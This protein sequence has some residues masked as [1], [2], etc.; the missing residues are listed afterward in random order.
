[1]PALDASLDAVAGGGAAFKAVRGEYGSGKTFLTRYVAE[2]A[3]GEGL[4][5]AEVQI[6]ETET[7]LH[8]LETVYRRIRE[9]LRTAAY[10]PSA[11]RPVLDSWLF[12]LESDAM[13]STRT[14][15]GADMR[16]STP[17]SSGCWRKGSP[18]SP[19]HTPAFRPG[20]ARLPCR[21]R[22]RGPAS[23]DALAILAWRAAACR[24]RR[25]PQRRNPRRTGSFRGDGIPAG[26][27]R[28]CS[29]T[30]AILGCCWCWTRSRPCS[31]SA[32]TYATR[33]STRS[34]SSSTRSTRGATRASSW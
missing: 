10:P 22:I 4:A 6:S 3:L 20:T 28:S 16:P 5:T 21:G 11:F 1:M 26:P 23:A 12:T 14:P 30:P 13:P 2:R 7:P 31:G 33:P 17:P 27:A 19:I 9:S 32:A 15:A 18:P 8:R 24:R 29:A 34:A 25:P